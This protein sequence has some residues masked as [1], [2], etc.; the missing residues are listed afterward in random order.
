M[1]EDRIRDLLGGFNVRHY[2]EQARAQ[3]RGQVAPEERLVAASLYEKIAQFRR[4]E[5]FISHEL[6]VTLEL[7]ERTL[8]SEHFILNNPV[9]RYP[10]YTNVRVLTWAL[11]TNRRQP[12]DAVWSHCRQMIRLLL[13]DLISF[14]VWS[15]AGAERWQQRNCKAEV[16]RERISLLQE[17][18]AQAAGRTGEFFHHYVGEPPEDWFTLALEESREA[19][20]LHLTTLPQTSQHDEVLFLR[21]IHISECIFWGILTATYAAV[22]DLKRGLTN[23]AVICLREA[24]TFAELLMPLFQAFKTMPP[25]HFA[26]FRD[27][28]GEASAIQSRTYQL[29]Q[30][31]TQGLDEKKMKNLAD[32]P[33]ISDLLLY[34]HPAFVHLRSSL[35]KIE[36]GR[37]SGWQEA[38]AQSEA[39][40]RALY[41]WRCLHLGIARNYLPPAVAGTGGSSGAPYLAA[42][43]RHKI[44]DPARQCAPWSLV[45]TSSSATAR[46]ILSQLN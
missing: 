4:E 23:S 33:E 35:N 16:V 40:D 21:T 19:A 45:G 41:A 24:T 31:F 12:L 43:F 25:E 44:I 17:V 8:F 22:E 10:A 38:K 6:F 39:L 5:K 1:T 37:V 28:T 36:E 20:V 14:E 15:L 27:A 34:A 13:K 46:P 9:P 7:A 30:I 29:M 11:K 2:I 26:E 3:G 18:H 32:T 42:H